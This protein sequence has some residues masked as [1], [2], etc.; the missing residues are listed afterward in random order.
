MKKDWIHFVLFILT[1]GTTSLAG[2]MLSGEEPSMS[3]GFLLKGL[4]FSASLLGILGVHELGH[5]F[6]SR[7][8][9]VDATLPFFIPFP[10][11]IG[12]FGAF[13]KIKSAIP[14]RRSLFD[15]GFAGPLFGFIVAIPLLFV[16]IALS[17]VRQGVEIAPVGHF[18]LGSSILVWLAERI[19]HGGLPETAQLII[20]P[21]GFA[22]WIGLWVTSINLLPIGQLDGGHIAYAVLGPKAYLLARWTWI[23]LLP[24]AWLW[25]GWLVWAIVV[26]FL[27]KL[28][29]PPTVFD[30]IPLDVRRRRLAL[31]A[32]A[33]FIL[34]F[35]PKPFG[36]F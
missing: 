18:S 23:A 33:I 14:D 26:L 4:P 9:G 15:I 5:Y 3:I 6:A 34:T 25:P 13:I 10:T 2:A 16:G 31:L 22:A 8:H 24:L 28:R 19:I 29:H 36:G 7:Y 11:I 17:E 1:I 35:I 32:L 12:T 27:I 21:V 20:H 30:W